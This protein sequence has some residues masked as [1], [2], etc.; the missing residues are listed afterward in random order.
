MKISIIGT[1][2]VGLVTGACFA[3][4][5]NSVTCVDNVEAKVERLRKGEIPFFEPGLDTLVKR[6]TEG[7]RLAFTTNINDAVRNADIHFLC[8]GTPYV[9]EVGTLDTRN[10]IKVATMIAEHAKN[11]DMIVVKSTVPVGTAAQVREAI[12]GSGKQLHIVSNP[13]FLKEG[14]AVEDFMK[15]DR[16]VIG[17][18][19]EDGEQAK[20]MVELYKTFV[21][22]GNPIEVMDNTS[23]E[24]VK[25]ASN[26]YL[27]TRISY[28]NEIANLCE[29]TGADVTKVR[30]GMGLDSRIG[31]R[32]LFPGVGYGGSCF[33]K[34]IQALIHTGRQYDFGARILT[35]VHDVN[36]HQR[37][38]FVNKL[39]DQFNG[40]VDGKVIAVWGLAFKANTDD[41]RDA[42]SIDIIDELIKGGA[43]VQVYDPEAMDN[44]REIFGDKISY[45]AENYGCLEGADALCVLTEWGVFRNP[46]FDKVKQ[47]M[48]QALIIDGRNL[49]RS[50]ELKKAGFRYL[51]VGQPFSGKQ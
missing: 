41:I 49:Y 27:A 3:D 39:M 20:T 7:S 45:A 2:Y 38:N 15:P 42:P 26:G 18:E 14:N 37:K 51:F 9:D 21:R 36:F 11:G 48:K 28:M 30:K 32:Y 34:D 17:L 1:G 16:V 13:E 44:V 31:N 12:A 43:K 5:G 35:A 25:L 29:T 47:L 46:D 24:M 19:D 22:S 50:K 8:V 4:T 40:S 10:L 23:A 6:N 33:P